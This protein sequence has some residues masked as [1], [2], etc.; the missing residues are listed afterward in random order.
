MLYATN[1]TNDDTVYRLFKLTLEALP[2]FPG[3]P[4]IDSLE[5]P[6][7]QMDFLWFSDD[8]TESTVSLINAAGIYSSDKDQIFYKAPQT[9]AS[10]PTTQMVL[11]QGAHFMIVAEES[12]ASTV[13]FDYAFTSAPNP[14]PDPPDDD[15][16]LVHGLK[17]PSSKQTS[18]QNVTQPKAMSTLE[19]D[20]PATPPPPAP[21]VGWSKT[22]GP[23]TISAIGLSFAN[24]TI[25]VTLNA[26][27]AFGPAEAII[28]GLGL[29][30][31][32]TDFSTFD[33]SKVEP[34][35]S[36]IGIEMNTLPV[37][38]SGMLIKKPGG[39]AGGIV[40]E[41]EPYTFLAVGS[42]GDATVPNSNPTSTY[43]TLFVFLALKGPIAELE[44][45]AAL[46]NLTGG[47]G[48]NSALTL[49]TVDNVTQFPFLAAASTTGNDPLDV[50]NKFTG[51]SPAWLAPGLKQIWIAAGL[52]CNAFQILEINSVVVLDFGTDVVLGVFAEAT[53]SI[54][55]DAPNTTEMFAFVDIGLYAIL[56]F[57]KGMRSVVSVLFIYAT[58]SDKI[59]RRLPMR[60]TVDSPKL[61]SRSGLPFVRGI[62]DVLLVCWLWP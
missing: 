58:M 27:I 57:S 51:S 11:S 61:Y 47:F 4:F 32:M 5:Q 9:S 2:T 49:P 23:L 40:I 34:L 31:P 52:G 59:S 62:R 50:L 21:T 8:M 44:G 36:G 3:L 48:W 22:I 60:G 13:I 15:A 37:V 18:T 45:I 1:L 43:K 29:S 39:F 19:D 42:Y 16:M 6:F 12:G 10:D 54:P 53:A 30:Y 56:D 41:V 35:I 14:P 38:V 24:S 26:K 33:M 7:D 46:E 28:D 17:L 25:Q 55:E 20:S